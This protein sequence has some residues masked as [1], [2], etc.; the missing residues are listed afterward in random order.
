MDL[1]NTLK[2][3]FEEIKVVQN[4]TATSIANSLNISKK[5]LSNYINGDAY[6]PLEHL[7]TISNIL[8]ISVDYILELSDIKLPKKIKKIDNLNAIDIGTRLKSIR[9]ELK[10]TQEELAK[11]IGINKSSISKYESG[12]NLILT[13]SLYTICKKYNI[14]ADYLLGKTD[15][16]IYIKETN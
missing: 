3:F 10:L 14:S 7:N 11:T 1:S 5:T 4:I 9:K 13:I 12:K 2:K 16:P 6:I 15:K 8:N